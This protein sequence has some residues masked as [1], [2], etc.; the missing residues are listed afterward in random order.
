ME[1]ILDV[2]R[3]QYGRPA[4][5]CGTSPVELNAVTVSSLQDTIKAVVQEE[6]RKLFPSSC[7][8]AATLSDVVR[9]E[10]QQAL[11]TG[12]LVPPNQ[13]PE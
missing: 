7:P 3:R 9:Q 5:T 13:E 6:L 8:Q 12:P 2:R 1:K 4:M 11:G 10:V